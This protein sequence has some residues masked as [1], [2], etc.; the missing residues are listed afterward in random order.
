M[1][2]QTAKLICFIKEALDQIIAASH[3]NNITHLAEP[4]NKSI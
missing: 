3:Q 2:Q 1:G 4:I